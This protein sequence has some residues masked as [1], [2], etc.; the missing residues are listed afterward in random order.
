[1]A[2]ARG[3]SGDG[4]EQGCAQDQEVEEHLAAKVLLKGEAGSGKSVALAALAHA[5]RKHGA[6]VCCPFQVPSCRHQGSVAKNSARSNKSMA[7]GALALNMQPSLVLQC[8]CSLL[9]STR[10]GE[11]DGSVA[12]PFRTPAAASHVHLLPRLPRKVAETAWKQQ[13]QPPLL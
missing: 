7:L 2:Y 3:E 11:P 12:L 13:R 5:L 6:V 1:M 10:V 4:E 9:C 8:V